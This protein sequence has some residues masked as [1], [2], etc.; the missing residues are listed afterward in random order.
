M[1]IDKLKDV[2]L[3]LGVMAVLLL[4]LAA[5]VVVMR[6]WYGQTKESMDDDELLTDFRNMVDAGELSPEEFKKIRAS[7]GKVDRA[8]TDKPAPRPAPLPP[9]AADLPPEPE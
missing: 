3:P 9:P 5:V 6:R 2:L 7:L 8:A 4:G 1:P